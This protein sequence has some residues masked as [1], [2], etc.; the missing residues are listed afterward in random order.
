MKNNF[1]YIL[2]ILAVLIFYGL[3]F[4]NITSK[5][6]GKKIFVDQK[7][8]SCHS[9]KSLDLISKK[10]DATDLSSGSKSWTAEFLTQYLKK[11]VKL[12]GKLHK[13][14]FKGTDDQLKTLIDWL[15][16]FRVQLK[17]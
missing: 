2:F 17:N 12:D 13:S 16:A 11:E 7:C 15:L 4:N 1:V 3:S 6:D 14:V 10:K 9:V 8:I 5:E